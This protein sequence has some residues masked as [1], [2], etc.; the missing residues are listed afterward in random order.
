M[1]SS[2]KR[3][4]PRP[5]QQ[6]AGRIDWDRIEIGLDFFLGIDWLGLEIGLISFLKFLDF[7]REVS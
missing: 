5:H 6:E 1:T 7:S 3:T 4:S 2:S